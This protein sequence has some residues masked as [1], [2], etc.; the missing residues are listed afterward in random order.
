MITIF[1]A[2]QFTIGIVGI[3]VSYK[4]SIFNDKT[5]VALYEIMKAIKNKIINALLFILFV[6]FTIL[7][8]AFSIWCIVESTV[9]QNLL[10]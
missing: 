8:T 9:I 3:I 7:T 5:N 6:I 10:N 2:L 1:K 4:I